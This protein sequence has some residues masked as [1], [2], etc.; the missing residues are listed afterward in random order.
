M[1]PL[2]TSRDPH[3]G[4]LST[5]LDHFGSRNERISREFCG[6]GNIVDHSGPLWTIVVDHYGP[7]ST[8]LDH[9][10]RPSVDPR[11]PRRRHATILYH[12]CLLRTPQRNVKLVSGGATASWTQWLPTM[13][14][15]GKRANH[16]I[17][18]AKM[19]EFRALG[20]PWTLS[21]QDLQRPSQETI[22]DHCQ[23][24]LTILDH[25]NDS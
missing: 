15:T 7:L 18:V 4:P 12:I 16:T 5:I 8:I 20:T 25:V 13:L 14:G 24:F 22:L 9:C 19:R 17:G 21:A 11:R 10:R 1:N 2:R 3:S 23:M 6:L